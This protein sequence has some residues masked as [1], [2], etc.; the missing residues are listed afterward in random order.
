MHFMVQNATGFDVWRTP[1]EELRA[2]IAFDLRSDPGE[3][4]RDGIGY[5]DWAYRHT[6]EFYPV[7][8]FV[9]RF[10]Y[11]F[12]QYPPRQKPGSFTVEDAFRM[13]QS[14]VTK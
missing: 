5:D 8:D 12:K 10:L 7:G 6:Y 13:I 11:T 9:G 1:F 4:G 3:R 2:P 14:G